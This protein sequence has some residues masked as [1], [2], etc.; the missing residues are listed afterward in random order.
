MALILLIDDDSDVLVTMS[1]FLKQHNY[2]VCTAS[3]IA[4]ASKQISIATPAVIL[5]D[6]LLSGEDGREFCR[7]VKNDP[8]TAG[9]YVIIFSGHPGAVQ[10]LNGFGADDFL[11][12]PVNTALLLEKLNKV[13][14][15]KDKAPH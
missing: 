3:N 2:E 12:K 11:S 10:R 1:A 7:T 8:S 15:E 4:E 6:V 5:L 13:T 9:I 14:T